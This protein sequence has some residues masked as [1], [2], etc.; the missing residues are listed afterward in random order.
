ML[1]K[2]SRDLP[3]LRVSAPADVGTAVG[4]QGKW[5]LLAK[6]SGFPHAV[7]VPPAWECLSFEL[8]RQNPHHGG[9]L[10]PPPRMAEW[11]LYESH[12][13]TPRNHPGAGGGGPARSRC[14]QDE[15]VSG[16][17][18]TIPC[19]TRRGRGGGSP[20]LGPRACV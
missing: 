7:W 1:L 3:S 8:V 18:Q 11:G 4:L 14:A 2:G 19:G 9:A 12:G 15:F 5:R 16:G 20:R 10:E 6:G 13:M 17:N